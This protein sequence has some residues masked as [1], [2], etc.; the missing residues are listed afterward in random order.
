MKHFSW[1]VTFGTRAVSN[2]KELENNI[3]MCNVTTLNVKVNI[4]CFLMQKKDF[5]GFCYEHSGG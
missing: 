2:Y 5:Q 3:V 1:E 4:Y